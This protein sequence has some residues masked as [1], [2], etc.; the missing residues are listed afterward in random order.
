GAQ[1]VA[2]ERC[3]NFLRQNP[4][5]DVAMPDRLYGEKLRLDA[6]GASLE[7]RWFGPA[8]G[9]CLSV[10][11]AR[12]AGLVQVVDLLPEARP[13]FPA[14]PLVANLRPHNLRAFFA[15]VDDYAGQSGARGVVAS[16]TRAAGCARSAEC[17]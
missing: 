1:V 3:A 13:A 8:H 11:H 2:Q 10:F 15:A 17:P 7:L 9:D 4:H 6:G 14:D 12:P 5:P 16:T